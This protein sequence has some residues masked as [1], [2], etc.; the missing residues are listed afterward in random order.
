MTGILME[1]S[2]VFCELGTESSCTLS[3]TIRR[4]VAVLSPWKSRFG[5][6]IVLLRFLV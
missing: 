5:S 1:R 6:G 3:M 4:L 2:F